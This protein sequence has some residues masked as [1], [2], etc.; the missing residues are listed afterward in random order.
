VRYLVRRILVGV[1]TGSATGIVLGAL[2]G[3]VLVATTTPAAPLGEFVTLATAGVV[4][5]GPLGAYIS[6]ER[7]GTLSDAWSTTFE[8][9]EAGATWVGV[10][11]HN[12]ADR[13]RAQRLFERVPPDEIRE[14]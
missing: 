13:Q 6:F 11:I 1:V 8:E 7:A 2:V 3:A 4:I 12:R 5:G 9:L 10:R 14:L